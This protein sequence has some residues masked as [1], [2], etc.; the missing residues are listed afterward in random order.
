MKKIK[1]V[2]L[3]VLM[4][5]SIA[6]FV[7]KYETLKTE[8]PRQE[9]VILE[10]ND[11]FELELHRE[12]FLT[13]FETKGS[14]WGPQLIQKS[15]SF[16]EVMAVLLDTPYLEFEE[17][18]KRKYRLDLKS[19][20]P[21]D[22]VREEVAALIFKELKLKSTK[23][24]YD[25]ELYEISISDESIM[26]TKIESMDAGVMSYSDIKNGKGKYIGFTLD[27]L[28]KTLNE[29]LENNIFVAASEDQ[30]KRIGIEI[31][32]INSLDKNLSDMKSQGFA[33][34]TVTQSKEFLVI[35]AE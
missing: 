34:K 32:N 2:L 12:K 29:N 17:G 30:S 1:V 23:S 20:V 8:G 11:R 5:L 28:A 21:L 24:T 14:A 26:K 25:L 10:K 7:I 13:A 33:V 22:E 35:S 6:S 9:A 19:S 4:L 16:E 27:Q 3:G 31:S 15:G 18:D